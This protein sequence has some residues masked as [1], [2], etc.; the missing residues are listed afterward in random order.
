MDNRSSR[1]WG[2]MVAE[3]VPPVIPQLS[4]YCQTSLKCSWA[5]R[6]TSILVLVITAPAS[7]M[8]PVHSSC[9]VNVIR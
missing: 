3:Q 9:S 7:R 5:P 4:S 6:H 2:W 8:G 1:M